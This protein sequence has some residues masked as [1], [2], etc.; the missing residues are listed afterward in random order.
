MTHTVVCNVLYI[1]IAFKFCQTYGT[2][3]Q[4]T[5]KIPRQYLGNKFDTTTLI[6][7]NIRGDKSSCVPLCPKVLE[8]MS[9]RLPWNSVPVLRS[10]YRHKACEHWKSRWRQWGYHHMHEAKIQDYGS[11]CSRGFP[12]ASSNFPKDVVCKYP[13]SLIVGH[14]IVAL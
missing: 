13:E 14:S 5:S 8:D 1:W 7:Q 2:L 9:T 11:P 6:S 4:W 12:K 3:H 10:T